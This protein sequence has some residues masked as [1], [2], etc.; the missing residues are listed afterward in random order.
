MEYRN[1]LDVIASLRYLVACVDGASGTREEMTRPTGGTIVIICPACWRGSMAV[2][3]DRIRDP[4]PNTDEASQAG[5][6][7]GFDA[8]SVRPI[9]S[10]F[11]FSPRHHRA[12]G[13]FGR[14]PFCLAA[15]HRDPYR[16]GGAGQG[17]TRV[18]GGIP[19]DGIRLLNSGPIHAAVRLAAVCQ[20]RDRKSTV[21][22]RRWRCL[23]G[24]PAR[25]PAR[26]H[27]RPAGP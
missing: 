10:S 8:S 3:P 2:G 13:R 7:N 19:I 26:R 23:T 6:I 9:A 14:L 25:L 11:G 21:M 12:F 5:A 24:F 18:A 27:T 22:S 20:D 4:V 16:L 15:R 17:S 1:G